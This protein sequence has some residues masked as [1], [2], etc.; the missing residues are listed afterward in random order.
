MKNEFRITVFLILMTSLGFAQTGTKVSTLPAESNK[1]Q[2]NPTK[3]VSTGNVAKGEAVTATE[4]KKGLNAVNVKT[5]KAT[6]TSTNGKTSDTKETGSAVSTTDTK[7]AINTKGT[8]AT[9]D[10]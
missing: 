8:G 2:T 6:E 1:T 7:H 4:G 9:R 10:K 5:A 3:S